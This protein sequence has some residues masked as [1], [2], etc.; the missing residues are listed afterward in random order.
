MNIL[1]IETE[2]TD[3]V[4]TA[5]SS[6]YR[7]LVSREQTLSQKMTRQILVLTFQL[8]PSLHT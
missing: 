1:D 5:A 6:G 7:L 4:A 3:L 8:Y 2:F